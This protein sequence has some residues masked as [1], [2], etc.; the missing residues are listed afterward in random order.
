VPLPDRGAKEFTEYKVGGSSFA[1]RERTPEGAHKAWEQ[2]CRQRWRALL[3]VIKAKLE[4]V[5]TGIT[6]F[7]DE[8]MAHIIMPDGLTAAQH[9]RPW[10]AKSYAS[11]DTPPL[12]PP[13][14]TGRP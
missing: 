7:E 2:A 8:F 11:G 9:V 6:S 14:S 10:I 1:T 5:E 12:L 13:P 4:A 3:L